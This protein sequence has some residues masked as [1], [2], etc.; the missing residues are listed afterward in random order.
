MRRKYALALPPLTFPKAM[1]LTQ[2]GQMVSTA[3]MAKYLGAT[4]IETDC[5]AVAIRC[6][7]KQLTIGQLFQLCD[8]FNCEDFNLTMQD[9]IIQSNDPVDF[10]GQLLDRFGYALTIRSM[11]GGDL[12]TVL[13]NLLSEIKE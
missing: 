8:Q 4:H 1:N 3:N 7:V 9:S 5:N 12:F 10:G 11:Q 6:E 2:D 13:K